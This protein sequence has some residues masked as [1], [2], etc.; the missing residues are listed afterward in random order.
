MLTILIFFAS[1]TSLGVTA[2]YFYQKFWLLNNDEELPATKMQWLMHLL[3]HNAPMIPAS[4]DM[5]K[6]PSANEYRK[7]YNLAI[8]VLYLFTTTYIITIAF[9]GIH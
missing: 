7:K 9:T 2:N 4:A 3:K 1:T 6:N 8:A 5:V